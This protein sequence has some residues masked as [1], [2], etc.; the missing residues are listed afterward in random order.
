MLKVSK[1][2]AGTSFKSIIKPHLSCLGLGLMLAMFQ[3][4]ASV[5][6]MTEAEADPAESQPEVVAQA[7]T[8]AVKE[9]VREERKASSTTDDANLEKK[10]AKADALM[11]T[12]KADLGDE[13]KSS[14]P[15]QESGTAKEAAPAPEKASQQ[16]QSVEAMPVTKAAS[17]APK[18][19]EPAAA[20]ETE[21]ASAAGSAVAEE[22]VVTESPE[23]EPAVSSGRYSMKDLPL[24]YD[25]WKIR[26]GQSRLDNDV[27]ITTPTW[28]MGEPGYNSQIWLTLMDDKLLV[29]SSSD[30]YTSDGKAGIRIDNGDLVP[31]SR[32]VSN[33][34]GVVDGNWLD[35]LA[36]GGKIYVYMGFFPDREPKS[37]IYQS[38][39]SLKNLMKVVNAYKSFLN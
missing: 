2:D 1:T 27:V 24:S 33:N 26:K 30:I 9:E 12:L 20:E 16:S 31:F 15:V 14:A 21:T 3:G 28:E 25:I 38:E 8:E 5:D 19:A 23:P 6:Q 4:C 32:I 37:G 22:P 18:K 11:A 10:Q 35:A 36:R 29:N 17:A 13:L 34:I 39:L 7:E